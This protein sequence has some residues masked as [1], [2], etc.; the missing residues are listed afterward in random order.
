MVQ[1]VK[2]VSCKSSQ[3]P[4]SKGYLHSTGASALVEKGINHAQYAD[5]GQLSQSLHTSQRLMLREQTVNTHTCRS[6]V[7]SSA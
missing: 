7:L 2:V 5:K 6:R 4:T 3:T 1:V